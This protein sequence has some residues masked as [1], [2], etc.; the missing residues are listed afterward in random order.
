MNFN[1]LFKVI[2]IFFLGISTAYALESGKDA[3][4]T[5]SIT[6]K[7]GEQVDLQLVFSD[8]TGET[9]PLSSFIQNGKPIILIPVYY[10]CP[11]LCGL[12]LNGVT[13]LLNSLKLDLGKEF[14][15]LTVSF[16][17]VETPELAS[18][19]AEKYRNQYRSPELAEKYWHFLVGQTASIDPL[20]K[21]IG[22]NYSPD[23]K[24]FSHSTAIMILT[25]EG[26]ISQY[27]TDINFSPWDVKLSLVEASQGKIGSPIDHFLL[28]CFKFDPS[29]GKYTWAAWN[30]VRIGVLICMAACAW[31][32]FKCKPRLSV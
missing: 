14:Q 16:N 6:T 3:V 13:T 26:K 20:M 4:A 28:F 11:R 10:D 23:G 7:L 25:P 8:S 29:K 30:V 24:E 17:A 21:Q 9:G 2:F 31:I 12:V 27:F 1:V 15:V 22:F 18:K 19:R 32:V 5:A